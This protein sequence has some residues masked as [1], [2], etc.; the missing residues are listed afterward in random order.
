MV[1]RNYIEKLYCMKKKEFDVFVC[2]NAIWISAHWFGIRKY[3]KIHFEF[4]YHQYIFQ[5]K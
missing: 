4:Y 2:S 5:K 3:L 1:A